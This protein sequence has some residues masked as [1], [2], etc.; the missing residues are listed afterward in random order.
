MSR[1]ET[2]GDCTLYLGDC[3]EI[4]RRWGRSMLS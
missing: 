3:L 2:I 4:C 1:V